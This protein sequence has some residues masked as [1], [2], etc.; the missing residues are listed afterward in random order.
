MLRNT[1]ERFLSYT[2][3]EI[4]LKS[5]SLNDS[6]FFLRAW[7]FLWMLRDTPQGG[8]TWSAMTLSESMG[9]QA[10]CQGSMIAV[11]PVLFYSHPF[12]ADGTRNDGW[13]KFRWVFM[14]AVCALLIAVTSAE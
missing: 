11:G 1:L 8:D 14:L 4:V 5:R 3:T 12:R 13:I 7:M 10:I 6:G 9:E 2:C